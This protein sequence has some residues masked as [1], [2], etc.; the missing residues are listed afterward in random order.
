MVSSKAATVDDYLD[1]LPADRKAAIKTLRAR[2]KRALPKGFKEVMQYGMI[3]WIIPL[4]R[5]PD[6]YNKQPLAVLSLAS[7]KQYMSLYLLGLYGDPKLRKW[8]EQAHAKTGKKL[9]MGKSCL[10]FKALPDLALDLVLEAVGKVD[11]DALI[12]LHEA[13][14]KSPK[15]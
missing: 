13:A 10:R 2:I 12:A 8:F 6:T 7:Q 11:A 14:H 5:F 9:D 3:S 1:T 4:T 15:R